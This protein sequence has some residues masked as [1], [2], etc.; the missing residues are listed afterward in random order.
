MPAITLID[1]LA[2]GLMVRDQAGRILFVNRRLHEIYGLTSE[3]AAIGETLE[4]VLCHAWGGDALAPELTA[5][6]AD[7]LN[8][9]GAPFAL[10]LPNDRWVR[11]S[12]RRALDGSGISTHVDITNLH[13]LQRRTVE[14]QTN[15][16]ALAASLRALIDERDRAEAA[17]RQSQRVE[18]VG[19]LTS[20]LAHDFNNLLSVMLA[21]LERLESSETDALRLQRLSVIRSAVD[22]GAAL[23]DKLLTFAR[24]Q[25]LQPSRVSLGKMIA[26]MVPLLRS[27]CG[28]GVAVLVDV[29]DNTPDAL[30]DQAQLEL[31]ILNLTIN[32]RD[33]MPKGGTLRIAAHT[34]IVEASP[35]PDAPTPGEYVVLSLSDNGTGMTEEVMAHAVEPFFTTKSPGS[36]SGLGLSQAF[37][38]ARQSGGTVQID[39]TL[40]VG[41]T[42]RV[43][44]PAAPQVIG[45]VIRRSEPDDGAQGCRILLV[46]DEPEILDGMS[47]LLENLRYQVTA[48]AGGVEALQALETGLECDLLVTDVRMPVVSGPDLA[49]WIWERKSGFP[50]LFITGFAEPNILA[51][52]GDNCRLLRKPCPSQDITAAIAALLRRG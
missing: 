45:A 5:T 52:L 34:E 10:E 2:D 26:E 36:G 44:L 18:A 43:L 23:T 9:A 29:P 20:G 25:P 11:V 8:F 24:K 22:R 15:A 19:Q 48:I 33:A 37:G 3:N 49:S 38:L 47:E 1:D 7:N 35:L 6:I 28:A 12:E 4:S 41:T 40:G 13:R 42:I 21:N 31:V 51:G 32:A 14:A 16:E 46:D 27:A 39:S 17:L 30:V 50:V